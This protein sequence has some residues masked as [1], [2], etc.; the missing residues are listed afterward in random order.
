LGPKGE[1]GTAYSDEDGFFGVSFHHKGKK[2]KYTISA[3]RYESEEVYL[4]AGRLAEVIL[5]LP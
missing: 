1:A 3:P 4:K 5:T 2:T